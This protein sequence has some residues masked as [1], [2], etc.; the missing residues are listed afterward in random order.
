MA[1]GSVPSPTLSHNGPCPRFVRNLTRVCRQMEAIAEL[2]GFDTDSFT[3]M[4]CDLNDFACVRKFCDE[5]KEFANEK[6]LDR[7]LCNAAVY[8]PSLDYAKWSKDGIEQQMQTNF[9]SHFL[10]ISLLMPAMAG[11]TGEDNPFSAPVTAILEPRTLARSDQQ[12]RSFEQSSHTESSLL[13][14]S[15]PVSM[16]SATVS[17]YVE[18]SRFRFPLDKSASICLYN[19]FS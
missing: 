16:C 2:D 12:A 10:M 7:L 17:L 18:I 19:T 6:P 9:L 11:A 13:F 3:A 5:V 1:T 15:V 14:P 8:Q 4:E